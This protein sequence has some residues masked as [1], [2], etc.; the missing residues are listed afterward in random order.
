MEVQ[1]RSHPIVHDRQNEGN[2]TDD[3]NSYTKPV[4]PSFFVCDP[5]CGTSSDDDEQAQGVR[6]PTE[7]D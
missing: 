3:G 4:A 7:Q 2:Q 6:E 1:D 5:E